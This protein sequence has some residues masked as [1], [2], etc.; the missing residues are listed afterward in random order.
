MRVFYKLI[1][2]LRG[3]VREAAETLIDTQ[4]LRIFEQEIYDCETSIQ[5]ARQDLSRVVTEK[6]KLG[7]E[8]KS[9][10]ES[11]QK[12]EQQA[13]EALQAGEEDLARDIARL[14]AEKE[15]TQHDQQSKYQ[16]LEAQESRLTKALRT[17]VQQ[18]KDY[19]RELR[20]LSATAS[21]QQASSRLATH[22]GRI[23][24]IFSQMQD[25]LNR[26]KQTQQDFADQME[27]T[28]QVEKNLSH[29]A[30][31]ERIASEGICSE[32]EPVSAVLNRIRKRLDERSSPKGS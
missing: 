32:N 24:S 26:I 4:A 11:L 16:Q 12:R 9:L 15:R 29:R 1:T 7:R 5:H 30:L 31:D 13:G 17:A 22:G 20:M 8:I 23:D 18:L 27:A 2:A 19:R 21:A 6:M 3:S 14:I 10:Q 25:S 28:M